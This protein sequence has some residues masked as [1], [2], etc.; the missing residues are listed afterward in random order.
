MNEE[1]PI[2][3]LMPVYNGEKYICEAIDSIL[4]QTFTN[5]EFLIINDGSV[6]KTEELIKSYSDRRI[7]LV[8]Q[9]NGGVSVALNTGLN[10]A[11]GKYIARFDADDICYSSRLEE[12]YKFLEQ[13]PEY[14]LIGG[15]A[16]YV[17]QT[18][19][20]VF[21]YKNTGHT[22]AEIREK[23]YEKNPII[24]STVLF[25][26]K[27]IKEIGGY[28][29][30]AYTFED[31]LLWVKL[32]RH[33]KVCNF[34]KP[35]I[36][37]RLNP[38]SVTTDERLRGKRFHELRK[39]ILLR[40]DEVKPSEGEELLQII[41]NQNSSKTKAL[42]YYHFVAK[43]YLWNN[44]QPSLSR[45]HSIAAIKLKP[46]DFMTLILFFLSFFPKKIVSNLYHYVK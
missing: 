21:S 5:F 11:L 30:K 25:P 4:N 16:D 1:I 39:E 7:K 27:I 17:S 40:G 34:K 19:E 29:V 22:D 23:I 14:V 12:Q 6:D 43:K 32:I 2:T 18:G 33:G 46:L 20:F 10:H 45:K 15:D 31:H 36:K 3:V 38:E 35:L 13:N 26:K 42:G 9:L 8:N 37:V 24:H 41:K 28:D 44:Y